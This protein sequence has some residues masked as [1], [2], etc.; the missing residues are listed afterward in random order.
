MNNT[1]KVLRIK[2]LINKIGMSRSTIY[3]WLNPK[4]P[5]YDETFPKPFKIG[6]SSIAWFEHDVDSWLIHRSQS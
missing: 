1:I 5:R 6:Q 4:S 3:D 2:D